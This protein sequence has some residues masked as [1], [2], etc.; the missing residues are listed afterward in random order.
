[1]IQ[2][3]PLTARLSAPTRQRQTQINRETVFSGYMI[4]YHFDIPVLVFFSPVS[5]TIWQRQYRRITLNSTQ[6]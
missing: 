4:K 5:Q 6:A 2:M 3:Y 1:M